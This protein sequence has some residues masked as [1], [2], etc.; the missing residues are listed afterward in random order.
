MFSNDPTMSKGISSF[1]YVASLGLIAY[2]VA[3]VVAR[4]ISRVPREIY[5]NRLICLVPLLVFVLLLVPAHGYSGSLD[6][7]Y[8]SGFDGYGIG[9]SYGM[10]TWLLWLLAALLKRPKKDRKQNC[11]A[12]SGGSAAPLGGS[13]CTEQIVKP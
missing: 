9:T 5:V 11:A 10:M 4:I 13:N 6:R 1:L 12:P 2:V 8:R 3:E 7:Y